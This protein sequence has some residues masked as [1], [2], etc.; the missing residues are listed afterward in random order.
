MGSLFILITNLGHLLIAAIF[1]DKGALGLWQCVPKY[2]L[3]FGHN[4]LIDSFLRSR[5]S[6][7]SGSPRRSVTA[8]R[9]AR[10]QRCLG[11][12]LPTTG[13]LLRH[14]KHSVHGC[15]AAS[16]PGKPVTW[17]GRPHSRVCDGFVLW[18]PSFHSDFTG[19][20]W[21]QQLHTHLTKTTS[22]HYR[23]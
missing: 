1:D 17:L 7:P 13:R 16:P 15:S 22:S 10:L 20:Q 12:V 4:I 19:F 2:F 21:P 3:L 8:W 23:V 5:P 11:R 18:P 6:S 14:N 9:P